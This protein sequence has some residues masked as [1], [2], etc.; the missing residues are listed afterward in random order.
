MEEFIIIGKVMLAMLLAGL[1]GL[2]R[3]M[4]DHSA[5]LR[6]HMLVGGASA[7]FV[8]L[9]MLVTETMSERLGDSLIEADPVRIIQAVLIGV[10]FLGAGTILH[11]QNS[12]QVVGLTTAASI[13]FVAGIGVCVAIDQFIIAAGLTILTLIVL[14]TVH[15][16]EKR[17]NL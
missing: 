9:G 15:I 6:T 14:H 8:T 5:G 1:I 17:L 2:E 16:L 13:L 7:L 10:S 11:K 4:K 12:G 3:E